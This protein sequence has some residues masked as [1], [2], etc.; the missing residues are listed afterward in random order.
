MQ[1]FGAKGF[2]ENASNTQ[3]EDAEREYVMTPGTDTGSPLVALTEAISKMDIHDLDSGE[4][5]GL[6]KAIDV[7]RGQIVGRTEALGCTNTSIE[8]ENRAAS[9]SPDSLKNQITQL[10]L[11]V[12]HVVGRQ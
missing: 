4:L 6:R 1:T 3:K 2:Q 11:D 5:S 12:E 7:L 9:G 10:W 8:Q